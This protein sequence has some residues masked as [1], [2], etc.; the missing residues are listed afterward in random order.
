MVSKGGFGLIYWRYSVLW[1]FGGQ[2]VVRRKGFP[3]LGVWGFW[4]G[5]DMDYD[6]S[7]DEKNGG[8]FRPVVLQVCIGVWW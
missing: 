1:A 6:G 5:G 8:V 3:S 2:R 7:G 4:L